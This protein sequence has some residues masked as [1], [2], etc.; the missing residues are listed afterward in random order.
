MSPPWLASHCST[1]VTLHIMASEFQG[2]PPLLFGIRIIRV[3]STADARNGGRR[4]E[5]TPI[6]VHNMVSCHAGLGAGAIWFRLIPSDSIWFHLI[7]W[8]SMGIHGWFPVE[9]QALSMGI[10]AQS[11]V[12][13][14]EKWIRCA[15]IWV[16]L[17]SAPIH[18]TPKSLLLL[19]MDASPTSFVCAVCRG[20]GS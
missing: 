18:L 14:E 9:V 13:C 17:Y 3:V 4:D 12:L 8:V 5:S 16:L 7:P 2:I 6:V 11:P 1:C 15:K 10:R 19:L 20:S